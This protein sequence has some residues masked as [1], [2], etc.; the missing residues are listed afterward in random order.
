MLIEHAECNPMTAGARDVLKQVHRSIAI[1]NKDVDAAIIV[2]VAKRGRAA[3]GDKRLRCSAA[4]GNLHE[5]AIRSAAHQYIRLGVRIIAVKRRDAKDLAI[6]L[7]EIEI[8]VV[9]EISQPQ[10]EAREAARHGGDAYGRCRIH[11]VL[12][13]IAVKRVGFEK[14]IADKQIE[15]AIV[16][17]VGGINSHSRLGRP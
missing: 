12:A 14:E 10:A 8:S 3:R 7:V 11:E 17:V 2:D 4:R 1:D 13:L 5:T 9:V 6:G 16:I 15:I